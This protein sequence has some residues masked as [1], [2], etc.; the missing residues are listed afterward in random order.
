VVRCW[1]CF[2]TSLLFFVF[3]CSSS[4]TFAKKFIIQIKDTQ[5]IRGSTLS[6]QISKQ[7]R[8][9]NL[10]NKI[11]T[12]ARLQAIPLQRISSLIAEAPSLQ[13]L[14]EQ[15][16]GDPNVAYI[17]EDSPIYLSNVQSDDYGEKI[18]NSPYLKVMGFK[19]EVSSEFIEKF[20]PENA[21]DKPLLVAVVDTGVN[22]EHPFI[23]PFLATNS[24]ELGLDKLGN[25]KASNKIDD[26]QNG[27][28]DD[29]YGISS[30]DNGDVFDVQYHGTHVSGLVKTIRDHALANGYEEALKV[31]LLPIRFFSKCEDIPGDGQICGTISSAIIALD[32]ALLRGAK[33]VNMSWGSFS[34]S[35]ALYDTLKE[36]Y[37]ND[38][39]L[40][41]AAGN[42]ASNV[43]D[44]PFYPAAY[45][46]CLPG[47][48]SVNSISTL[49]G[50]ENNLSLSSFSN[51]SSQF[52]SI[53]APGHSSYN[54]IFGLLSANSEYPFGDK[55]IPLSGTSMASPLVAGITAVMKSLNPALTAHDIQEVLLSSAKVP[56]DL[57]NNKVLNQKNLVSGY[58]HA[59]N[60]FESALSSPHLKLNN[61]ESCSAIPSYGFTSSSTKEQNS[62]GGG[63]AAIISL[64]GTENNGSNPFGGNSLGLLSALFFLVQFI[65][66]MRY[67]TQ[68]C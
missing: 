68:R 51:Y 58:A 2:L 26:D 53:A 49:G 22:I 31:Q 29:V 27:Y 62:G 19:K 42:N 24:G 54:G 66:S 55:F 38:M 45:N 57:A 16:S 15:I 37:Q 4:L 35:R 7:Q 34:N 47:L 18:S 9:I 6:K 8:V 44:F 48:I 12:N 14:E 43:D 64:N 40:V 50:D 1:S 17:E 28:I 39:T 59:I 46:S 56:Y 52:V 65:R 25:D 30:S 5:I 10:K 36:L 41:A 61:I 21:T 33:I 60:S 32:Y 13:D 20:T 3:L 67:K 63:C 23:K 11:N